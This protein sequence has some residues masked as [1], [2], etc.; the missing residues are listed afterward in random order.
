MPDGSG[1]WQTL[2]APTPGKS[3]SSAPISVVITEIMYHPYHPDPGTEDIGAEY[4]E[5]FNRGSEPVSLAGWR[6]INGVDFVFP[7]VTIG[8]GEYLVVAAD[9][10]IIKS[11]YPWVSNVV[12]GWVGRLSNRGEAIE[13]L[14]DAGVQITCR[15]ITARTGPQVISITARPVWKTRF[16]TRMSHPL[17]WM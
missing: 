6:I 13:I 4:I 1:N 9:A 14:D 12:G 2:A 10:D 16:T 11:M 7:D 17:F 8:A 5:L 15:T 3:N